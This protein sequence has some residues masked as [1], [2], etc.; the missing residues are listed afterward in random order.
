MAAHPNEGDGGS[1][2][3]RDHI[4]VAQLAR[5]PLIRVLLTDWT[6]KKI[7]SMPTMVDL[8]C[9]KCETSFQRDKKEVARQRRNGRKIFYCNL[10]CGAAANESA[11]KASGYDY[12]VRTAVLLENKGP[13]RARD[14]FSC[15]REYLRR[16]RRRSVQDGIEATITLEDLSQQWEKQGGRCPYTGWPLTLHAVVSA[17]TARS[18][19]VASL[20]RIRTAEGYVAGN[21]QFVA[22]I[23]NFAKNNFSED[24]L[25]EFCR[26]V[27]KHHGIKI[28]AVAA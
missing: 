13:G 2:P 9:G 4:K 22:M 3:P 23:A 8:I 20:D 15:F 27:A 6:R 21:I 18:P 26:A 5:A 19:N 25:L 1:N 16:A 28:A 24:A 11:R 7:G 17:K 12:S 10:A 14:Q